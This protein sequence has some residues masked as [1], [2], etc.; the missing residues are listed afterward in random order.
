MLDGK[1]LA[2]PYFKYDPTRYSERNILEKTY[3]GCSSCFLKDISRLKQHLYRVHRRPDHYCGRCS[4]KFDSQDALETHIRASEACDVRDPQYAEKMTSDQ[5]TSIKRRSP[6]RSPRETWYIIFKILFPDSPLP[7]NPFAEWTS[8]DTIAA[9]VNHAERRGPAMLSELISNDIQHLPFYTQNG[10]QILDE[11]IE[12]AFPQVIRE[13]SHHPSQSSS[14][15]DS[16]SS[17]SAVASSLV[18][19]SREQATALHDILSA[20]SP[21][22][23]PLSGA[24]PHS[25]GFEPSQ[26][27]SNS[28]PNRLSLI[29]IFDIPLI[30]TA[31]GLPTEN[32]APTSSYMTDSWTSFPGYEGQSFD[33][34]LQP[35]SFEVP[36][37]SNLD[38]RYNLGDNINTASRMV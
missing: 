16:S 1:L 23:V 14:Q 11:A 33:E 32:L 4:E 21:D 22:I 19:N 36:E 28:G 12:R 5:L 25:I 24:D 34:E 17:R 8:P 15:S 38:E 2:C 3:R 10:R 6:G 7:D 18:A 31:G 37:S 29:D 26:L 20:R 30:S 13:L 35:S 9:F 27:P